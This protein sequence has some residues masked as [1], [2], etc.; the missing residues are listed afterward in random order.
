MRVKILI[1]AIAAIPFGIAYCDQSADISTFPLEKDKYMLAE[2]D[3]EQETVQVVTKKENYIP[4]KFLYKC[5]RSAAKIQKQS[6][7]YPSGFK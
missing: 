6:G 5:S 7:H 2:Y 1:L 3:P 4:E